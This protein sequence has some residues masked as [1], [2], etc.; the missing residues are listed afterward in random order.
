MITE[1]M[2]EIVDEN[3]RVQGL[4]TRSECHRNPALR[5]RVVHVLVVSAAGLFLQ[6][7]AKSKDIQPGKWDT[8]VGGHVQPGEEL[9]AAAQRELAEELGIVTGQPLRFLYHYEMRSPVETEWV[10]TFEL[11]WEGKIFP[12]PQ[13]IEEGRWW[14]L[15]EIQNA[16]GQGGFTPNFEDEFQRWQKY[17]GLI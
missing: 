11:N 2:F 6:K 7:R 15:S 16:L 5:H 10:A 17:R 4:A 3:G 13:E 1:E 14:A 12:A 9:P 8:S